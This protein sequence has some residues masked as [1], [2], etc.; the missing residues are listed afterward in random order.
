MAELSIGTK[1]HRVSTKID[2]T[3]MVDLGFLLITFFILTANLIKTQLLAVEI[4]PAGESATTKQEQLLTIV[5]GANDHFYSYSGDFDKLRTKLNPIPNDSTG[6]KKWLE[7]QNQV[8][9]HNL[10]LPIANRSLILTVK[11]S[12]ASRLKNLVDVMDYISANKAV[13][14]SL[15]T[16]ETAEAAFLTQYAN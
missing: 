4:P 6:F 16:P 2:F 9:K 14:G 12:N 1:K 3:P 10:Q 7:H 5:L 13:K 8:I 15:G 11:A